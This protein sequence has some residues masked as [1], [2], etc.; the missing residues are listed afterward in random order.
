MSVS[1]RELAPLQKVMLLRIA[2]SGSGA[3]G[4]SLE[5]RAIASLRRNGLLRPGHP[6]QQSGTVR[7][8]WYLTA[9]ARRLIAEQ[10]STGIVQNHGRQMAK[11]DGG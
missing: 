4:S 1:W 2:Q 3:A 9:K 7:G 5:M 11:S 6:R 10:A 8:R